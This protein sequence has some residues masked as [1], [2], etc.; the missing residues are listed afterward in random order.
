MKAHPTALVDPAAKIAED[1]EIGPFCVVG[2]QVVLGPGCRL[3]GRVRIDGR[4]TAGRDNVFHP[5]CVVGGPPQDLQPPAPDARIQIGDGNVFRE[6]VTVNLP[7]VPGSPTRIGSRNRFH[8]G[9]HVGHDCRIGD[10][11]LLCTNAV[12]GGHS[13]LEDRC[14]V[15]GMGGTHQFVTVGRLAWSRTHIPI[16]EDVPPFM[17]VDGNHF[18]VRGVN[19]ACRTE[20]LEKAYATVWTSGLPRSESVALLEKDASPEVRELAAFLRRSAGGRNGRAEEAKR[21]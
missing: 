18:E 10:D 4:V 14:R 20:A 6:S 8:A 19:P 13:V 21:A 2:P 5:N 15:E 12:L 11:A 16:T 3:I 7:K 1:V 17:V 9:A